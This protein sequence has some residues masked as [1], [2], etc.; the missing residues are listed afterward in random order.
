VDPATLKPETPIEF[1]IADP[2]RGQG[3]TVWSASIVTIR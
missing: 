3:F 2:E 1:R